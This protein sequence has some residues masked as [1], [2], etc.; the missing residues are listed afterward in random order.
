MNKQIDIQI[1]NQM[2]IENIEN[3]YINFNK[4]KTNDEYPLIHFYEKSI[5]NICSGIS[6]MF[7]ILAFKKNNYKYDKYLYVF[8]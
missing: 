3:H 7:E 4:S 2:N 6:M 8:D 5:N 1:N